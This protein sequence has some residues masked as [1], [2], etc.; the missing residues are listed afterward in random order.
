MPAPAKIYFATPEE[1]KTPEYVEYVKWLASVWKENS[2]RNEK[3][4]GL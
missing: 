3:K 4:K 1:L 2:K